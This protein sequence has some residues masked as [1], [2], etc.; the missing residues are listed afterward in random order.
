M[1]PVTD[2]IPAL[3]LMVAAI[4]IPKETSN[5]EAGAKAI[6]LATSEATVSQSLA[7]REVDERDAEQPQVRIEAG[8]LTRPGRILIDDKPPASSR[9]H[10]VVAAQEK[11]YA[12]DS[13][14]W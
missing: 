2:Y 12:R 9:W 3:A 11:R 5:E 6:Q 1:H 7:N 4:A 13:I 8:F 10:A 14:D